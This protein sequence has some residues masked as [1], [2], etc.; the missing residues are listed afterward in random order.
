M[1]IDAVAIAA[2][3]GRYLESEKIGR[4]SLGKDISIS[5]CITEPSA[6]FSAPAFAAEEG[7]D[8]RANVAKTG[9]GLFRRMRRPSNALLNCSRRKAR[10]LHVKINTQPLWGKYDMSTSMDSCLAFATINVISHV[11]LL[12]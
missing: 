12:Q 6:I 1:V 9:H 7:S 10:E 2:E 8:Q 11:A 4:P 5:N 3:R